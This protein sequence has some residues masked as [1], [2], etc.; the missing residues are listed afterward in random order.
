MIFLMWTGWRAGGLMLI[1]MALYKS[2]ILTAQKSTRF[3]IVSMLIGFGLG[4]PVVIYGLI[5]NFAAHWSLQYSMFLG[6]QFNY[7]GSLFVA[8]GYIGMIMLM[9]QSKKYP[10]IK[11]GLSSVGRMAL[12]N[13]LFQTI[14]CTTVFYGHGLGLFGQIDRIGQIAIVFAIWVCQLAI[15]PIWLHHFQYGPFEWIWRS[16]SYLKIQPMRV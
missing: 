8:T 12:T 11:S 14:I 16:F 10:T 7:W 6:W 13:Y 15:S 2:G 3:Y 1:G 4:L 9:C 5:S